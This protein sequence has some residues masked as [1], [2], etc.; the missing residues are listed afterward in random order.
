[1]DYAK[2]VVFLDG[3]NDIRLA[4]FVEFHTTMTDDPRRLPLE[5]EEDGVYLNSTG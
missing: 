4:A 5:S 2:V 3:T 1:M